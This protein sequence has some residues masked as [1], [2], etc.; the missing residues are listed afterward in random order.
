MSLLKRSLAPWALAPL[1]PLI[2]WQGKQVR[3]N[4]VR[5]P[6]AMGEPHFPATDDNALSLLHLGESTVA[7]VGVRHI[8][9]G[10]TANI[11]NSLQRDGVAASAWAQG[12]NGATVAEIN[13]LAPTIIHPDILLVTLGVNDTVR[14]TSDK[15]WR[16][17][18]E[19]CV[20]RFAG[21]DTRVCF[22]QVPDMAAFPA[23]PAPLNQFLGLRASKLHRT[24]KSLCLQKKWHLL[25]VDLPVAEHWMAKDGYHPNAEGYRIWGESIA[26][27]LK[28]LP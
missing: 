6:E 28:Q 19:L 17:Q 1:L 26:R 4:T 27:Q 12:H 18:L 3:R 9:D 2:L 24:L 13:T 8:R 14:M 10:L 5:L 7:G 23:L 22:T 21:P 11:I 25:E 16:Q 20:A 15:D